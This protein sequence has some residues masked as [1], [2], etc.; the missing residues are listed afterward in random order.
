CPRAAPHLPGVHLVELQSL[1]SILGVLT[2]L[3]APALL[4]SASATFILSTVTRLVRNVDQM[5][6]LAQ[7]L[8]RP[9]P[10]EPAARAFLEAQLARTLQRVNLQQRALAL[11]YAAAVIFVACSLALGMEALTQALPNW[12]PVVL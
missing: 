12:L 10:I 3:I 6:A 11:F 1:S 8:R 2:A 7:R 9:E 5:R 4:I